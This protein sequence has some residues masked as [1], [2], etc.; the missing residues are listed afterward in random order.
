MVSEA[1][2]DAGCN[3][4][5]QADEERSSQ[6]NATQRPIELD[7]DGWIEEVNRVRSIPA[8]T[9]AAWK[10]KPAPI[11][12]L[13]VGVNVEGKYKAEAFIDSGIYG[14]GFDGFIQR[15]TA[16]K[17]NLTVQP[18]RNIISSATNNRVRTLGIVSVT[19]HEELPPA[20]LEVVEGILTNHEVALGLRWLTELEKSHAL[21]V[22]F[23]ERL[24][25]FNGR[26][27]A[28][29]VLR[30]TTALNSSSA[31]ETCVAE[32]TS[33]QKKLIELNENCGG[34]GSAEYCELL[35]VMESTI[36]ET[37]E[38]PKS[39]ADRL[40]YFLKGLNEKDKDE[41]VARVERH[42]ASIMEKYDGALLVDS[43]PKGTPPERITD[44][45]VDL[46]DGEK[47]P[48]PSRFNWTPDKAE[49]IN[50]MV[51][52]LLDT[53][54]I[55][56]SKS[57]LAAAC[58]LVRQKG[59]YR[60]VMDYRGVNAITRDSAISMPPTEHFIAIANKAALL[61]KADLKSA[62]HQVL[63]LEQDR[64]KTAFSCPMGIFEF[65]VVPFGMKGSPATMVATI[66]LALS[67]LEGVAGY[68]DDLMFWTN[69]N[70]LDTL[71][72]KLALVDA[73]HATLTAAFDRLVE[74]QH[75]LKKEKDL[76]FADVLPFLGYELRAGRGAT[77]SQDTCA[78]L[79]SIPP[80]TNI[81]E[82][83]RWIGSLNYFRK[84]FENMSAAVECV[85]RA[86]LENDFPLKEEPLER[87]YQ[88]RKRLT[89]PPVT[90][91]PDI[92]KPKMLITDASGRWVGAV[93]LQKEAD[94][95]W[96]PV[97]FRSNRLTDE[98]TRWKIVELEAWAAVSAMIEWRDWLVSQPFIL[99][100]D[101]RALSCFT[102]SKNEPPSVRIIRWQET[103]GPFS[104]TLAWRP[105]SDDIMAAA[106][107]LSRPEGD[108][109]VSIAEVV[110]KAW[111]LKPTK[112]VEIVGSPPD[113]G[114]EGDATEVWEMIAGVGDLC[115]GRILAPARPVR[116]KSGVQ[117]EGRDDMDEIEALL[118]VTASLKERVQMRIN[119]TAIKD[120]IID[121]ELS[122]TH[123]EPVEV[124]TH[125]PADDETAS[126]CSDSA[127][128]E[129]WEPSQDFKTL[130]RNEYRECSETDELLIHGKITGREDGLFRFRD[131]GKIWVPPDRRVEPEE[132]GLRAASPSL[133]KKLVFTAHNSAMH[134]HR[135]A[136]STLKLLDK[137][138]WPSIADDVK[139]WCKRCL[140]CARSKGWT[141][142]PLGETLD[143]GTP[144]VP[145][146]H[147]HVDF[148]G[149]IK[150]K[151]RLCLVVDRL[152]GFLLVLVVG[153]DD[154]AQE[155]A[156]IIYSRAFGLFGIPAKLTTDNDTLFKSTLWR[157]IMRQ[158]GVVHLTTVI[159]RP[160]ANGKVERRMRTVKEALTAVLLE[161]EEGTSWE[162]LVPAV[163]FAINTAPR[164]SRPSPAEELLG[165]RPRGPIEELLGTPASP[166]IPAGQRIEAARK[167]M[168]DAFEAMKV[169][170]D[171]KRRTGEEFE[172]GD[173][174]VVA[175]KA[176][177]AKSIPALEPKMTAPVQVVGVDGPNLTVRFGDSSDV[178]INQDSVRKVD[179]EAP[180]GEEE[181]DVEEIT[182]ARQVKRGAKKFLQ[183]RIKW[184][185]HD[186]QTW[187]PA[188][189]VF[190]PKMLEEFIRRD[191][192]R[193]RAKDLE[194]ALQRALTKMEKEK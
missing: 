79:A 154:N 69:D 161:A 187:E 100:T 39:T 191:S 1:T 13:R 9:V 82:G 45:R 104:F 115:S 179:D 194:A 128:D 98:Q 137:F 81:T 93:L 124:E 97:A 23:H 190:A 181:F 141:T 72:G 125:A 75:Y 58:F 127:T 61:S 42:V 140:V 178:R 6:N 83:R 143:L 96:H 109:H 16:E 173:K 88:L 177:G 149:E 117:M 155:T 133:R 122:A 33:K 94:G 50:K 91:L 167:A 26:D 192:Q 25:E 163:Q 136:E 130:L 37:E 175:K 119:A 15:E 180:L 145:F 162:E 113:D 40:A 151:R 52:E 74:K 76:F 54:L 116:L 102:S 67:G 156:S 7:I 186:E 121:K 78:A 118:A 135:H 111:S 110:A 70:G 169:I 106:D 66:N 105:G 138:Y 120:G 59:K 64:W 126:E 24:L 12:P 80:P 73:H 157:Q 174:V 84:F 90:V 56:P 131:T 148:S 41:V 3:P 152:T 129:D 86:I 5:Q 142:K 62:F 168:Q 49:I 36:V 144:E 43:L 28:R 185:G 184:L 32:V 68:V 171:R 165:F 30:G 166:R 11:A 158:A 55:R 107:L 164:K 95:E 99:I 123:A 103:I 176:L 65:N 160:Q 20:T 48:P 10:Q 21:K 101:H 182:D 170:R 4:K 57:P 17:L 63:V 85:Q 27:G 77:V 87:F 172:T 34:L 8:A 92:N 108:A 147:V 146:E 19:L 159:Y 134:A 44:H 53:G 71:D 188:G 46:V 18:A 35:F 60:L 22:H 193:K 189:E 114:S 89:S 112:C 31:I 29:R 153:I 2:V 47:L 183:L 38:R 150:N 139:D 14:G 51:N 132:E